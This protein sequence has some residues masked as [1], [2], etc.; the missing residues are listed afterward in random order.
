MSRPITPT[1][2]LTAK[3]TEEFIAQV[4]EDLQTSLG[5]TPTPKLKFFKLKMQRGRKEVVK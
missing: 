4:E 1:P 3:E 2:K 5:L